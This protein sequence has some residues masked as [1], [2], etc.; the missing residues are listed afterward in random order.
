MFMLLMIFGLV[1]YD[2]QLLRITDSPH[3]GLFLLGGDY[4]L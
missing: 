3:E 1:G 2:K 4:E